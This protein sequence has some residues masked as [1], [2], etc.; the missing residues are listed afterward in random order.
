MEYKH[1]YGA[2][3]R[4]GFFRPSTIAVAAIV[5]VSLVGIGGG[6]AT[7]AQ[8]CATSHA[9]WDPP[10]P[11]MPE[12]AP[13]VVRTAKYLPVPASAKGPAVDPEK[14]YRTESLGSGAFLVTDGIYQALVIV[15]SDGVIM[16]DAPPSIGAK[17]TQAIEDVAPGKHITH[18]IYSHAHVDH[19]GFASELQKTNPSMRIIAHEETQK[20]LARANDKR[21]PVPT[22]TFGGIGRKYA[23]SAGGQSL[24]LE[25][26]GPNHEPGNIEIYHEASRTL[27]LV[28]VV[29]PGWMMWRRFALAQDIPGYFEVVRT[30]NGKYDFATLVGGHLNRVGTKA[31]VT[32]QLEFMSDIHAAANDAISH[33]AMGEGLNPADKANAWAVF[34]NFID[35]V[36]I[37]CVNAVTPK[38]KSRLA[39][40]DVYIYDQC[41]SMEQSLRLDGPSM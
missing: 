36:T 23:V 3:A 4:T 16:V 32:T 31:D 18:L 39:G 40:Y 26:P 25:Y 5:L 14:G 20:L 33:V 27:M 17:I 41:L 38:W 24:Q 34:D 21:R 19:I 11:N 13:P 7:A 15:H 35:R 30:L 1:S 10:Y 29:F 22:E 9:C 2:P 12:I 28:D 6:I 8:K 37:S